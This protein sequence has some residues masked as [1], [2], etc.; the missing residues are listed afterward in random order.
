MIRGP[1]VPPAVEVSMRRSLTAPILLAAALFAAGC[2]SGGAPA[3]STEEPKPQPAAPTQTTVFE[4]ARG[5]SCDRSMKTCDWKGGASVG[6]TRLFFGDAAADALMPTM[7]PDGYRYDPIFKPG[8]RSSCDTLVTTCYDESGASAE[9]TSRY[10]GSKAADRLAKRP[11]TIQR[12]GQ[13][14]TCDRVSDVCYDRLGAGVG[15]TR[16][17]IG[18]PQSEALLKRLRADL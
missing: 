17:Y 15:I 14:I 16:L 11:R 7:A 12:Y 13:Y 9:L 2:Q 3:T 1:G 5:V 8:V 10:F 4:P 18:E 6:L